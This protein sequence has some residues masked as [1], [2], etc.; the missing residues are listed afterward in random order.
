MAAEDLCLLPAARQGGGHVQGARRRLPAEAGCVHLHVSRLER[1]Q[2]R[3]ERR[4]SG[5]ATAGD[6][7]L[8]RPQADRERHPDAAGHAVPAATRKTARSSRT[9]IAS[10]STRAPATSRRSSRSWIAFCRTRSSASGCT[11]GWRTSKRSRRS[12]ARRCCSSPIPTRAC[13]KAS[14]APAA[15]CSS[16]SCTSSTARNIRGPRTST[17]STARAARRPTPTGGTIRCWSP[18]TR[19]SRRRHRTGAASAARSMRC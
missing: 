14:S 13:A 10:R 9:S 16:R 3:R 17:S 6:R 7:R 2:D 11:T 18:S 15:A 19:P 1:A 8:D 4:Y 5:E 12:P